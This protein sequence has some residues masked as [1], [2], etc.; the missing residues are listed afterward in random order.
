MKP[1]FSFPY[2]RPAPLVAALLLLSACADD[3]FSDDVPKSSTRLSFGLNIAENWDKQTRSDEANTSTYEAYHFDDSPLWVVAE[4]KDCIETES[5]YEIDV[6]GTR[7]MPITN[8]SLMASYHSSFGV[9]AYYFEDESNPAYKLYMPGDEV[10]G[11]T[12]PTSG[13]LQKWVATSDRFWPAKGFMQFQA[14]SPYSLKDNIDASEDGLMIDYTINAKSDE[15]PDLLVGVPQDPK[16]AEYYTCDEH[17][18][19]SINFRHLL[20]AVKVRAAKDFKG[21][22]TKVKIEGVYGAGTINTKNLTIG[23][24]ENGDALNG[25][26]WDWPDN[27]SKSGSYEAIPTNTGMINGCDNLK[28]NATDEEKE[29]YKNSFIVNDEITF[30]LLPQTLTTDAKLTVEFTDEKGASQTLTSTIG[31]LRADGK[32]QHANWLMGHTVIYN[33]SYSEVIETGSVFDAYETG[34]K[35][36]KI[37]VGKNGGEIS[38]DVISHAESS[39][40][41]KNPVPWVLDKNLSTGLD[42]FDKNSLNNNI[43]S[44]DGDKTQMK[45]WV[46]ANNGEN[47]SGGFNIKNDQNSNDNGVSYGSDFADLSYPIPDTKN[48]AQIKNANEWNTANCYIISHQKAHYLPFIYGNGI[49]NG[50]VNE[51]AFKDANGKYYKDFYGKDITTPFIQENYTKELSEGKYFKFKVIW[52]DQVN[53]Q[54][55]DHGLVDA[56]ESYYKIEEADYTDANNITHKVKRTKVSIS[57]NFINDTKV[58]QGNALFGLYLVDDTKHTESLIWTWHIWFTRYR[59]NT[60]KDPATDTDFMKYNLGYIVNSDNGPRHARLVFRQEYEGV[61]KYKT[62]EVVQTGYDDKITDDIVEASQ[63]A[64]FF[65][66]GRQVPIMD[67]EKLWTWTPGTGYGV[68]AKD[69]I[70]VD[71]NDLSKFE[72]AAQHADAFITDNATRNG[73]DWYPHKTDTEYYNSVKDYLWR[74]NVKTVYD[75]CPPGFMV[76]GK[77]AFPSGNPDI[78][79]TDG[80]N[81]ETWYLVDRKLYFGRT[82]RLDYATGKKEYKDY[83]FHWTSTPGFN[84]HTA[85]YYYGA[86]TECNGGSV[87]GL[88]VVI[89]PIRE[90]GILPLPSEGDI[91]VNPWDDVD[92]GDVIIK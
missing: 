37:N 66:W 17:K 71:V 16:N 63:H 76:P 10:S 59:G 19:V 12:A 15:Q 26:K 31:G 3:S 65:Q 53:N 70:V 43:S 75:P 92:A 45:V 1:I 80:K 51:R 33:V 30:M 91:I 52:M 7:S 11:L 42:I 69:P 56:Q 50:V 87:R 34:T 82:G 68:V 89:R 85:Y 21:K 6:L 38:L 67:S 44:G 81:V 5:A 40:N 86:H 84:T 14:F 28:E 20:T 48:V 23:D 4:E 74:E 57:T 47:W 49:R 78:E 54:N 35:S 79:I 8:A 25:N 2:L 55:N 60:V 58:A 73:G 13:A 41:T 24:A 61:I 18:V 9:Y 32:G 64:V 90:K 62:V 77:D 46:N 88:G 39:D 36:T 22:F 27:A 72:D 29:A 83:A